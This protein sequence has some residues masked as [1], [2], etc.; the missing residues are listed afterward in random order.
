MY[1]DDYAM[2]SGLGGKKTPLHERGLHSKP[3]SWAD[4]EFAV[5]HQLIFAPTGLW[6]L[7]RIWVM[8]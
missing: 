6:D 1:F 5:Y 7:E 8:S 4:E 2:V 3:C